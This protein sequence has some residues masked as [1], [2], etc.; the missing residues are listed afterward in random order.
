M[1]HDDDAPYVPPNTELAS[2]VNAAPRSLLRGLV[3]SL[4]VVPASTLI[5]FGFLYYHHLAYQREM[6][7]LEM[8]P[9][10]LAGMS[11]FGSGDLMPFALW[12]IGLAILLFVLMATFSR[13]TFQLHVMLRI[14]LCVI[15]GS[16]AGFGWTLMVATMLG[17]WM[18]AFSFP[19]LYCWIGGSLVAVLASQAVPAFRR[20][21]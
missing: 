13:F 3:A 19:T 20:G 17:P 15:L 21:G 6:R 9:E 4:V 18:G 7:E 1:K 11:I 12:S 10:M 14:A 5:A 16:V 2:S 8:P